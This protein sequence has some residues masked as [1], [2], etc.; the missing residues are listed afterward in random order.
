MS[1][2]ETILDCAL[3]LFAERGYDAVGVQEIAEAAGIQKPTLY[4]YFGNKVGLLNTLLEENFAPL[5]MELE[6][7]ASY[8]HDVKNTLESV[9]T[10][11]FTYANNHRLFY[12][13]QLGLWFAP[14][15]SV[16]FHAVY[17]YDQKQ[18]KLLE[19]LF[20]QASLDHG[21]MKGREKAYAAAFLGLLH[22]YGSMGINGMVNFDPTF[23]Y[24]T[25][26]QFMHG[27]F[28]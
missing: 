10:V 28:S 9:A 20:Y 26:H 13:L 15:D 12:R 19:E 2:R 25:V 1:N 14:P 4:H 3:K 23:V 24:K 5:F 27:I 18:L 7:S 17:P 22:T 16:A 21:N 8:E 6:K 11:Y